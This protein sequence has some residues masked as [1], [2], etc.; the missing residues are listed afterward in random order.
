MWFMHALILE[1]SFFHIGKE[2]VNEY[3]QTSIQSF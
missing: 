3:V 2:G 1:V